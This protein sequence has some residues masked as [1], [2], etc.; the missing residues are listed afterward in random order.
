MMDT[1]GALTTA[2]ETIR[3]YYGEGQPEAGKPPV[4]GADLAAVYAGHGLPVLPAKLTEKK[5]EPKW[6][7]ADATADKK[8]VRQHWPTS[9]NGNPLA[10]VQPMMPVAPRTGLVVIDVDDASDHDT[11]A[12]LAELPPTLTLYRRGPSRE[13][14]RNRFHLVY[15]GTDVYSRK[16]SGLGLEVLGKSRKG[17]PGAVVPLPFDQRSKTVYWPHGDQI[18]DF[19]SELIELLPS[20]RHAE[21]PE[22]VAPLDSECPYAVAA[23]DDILASV[24]NADGQDQAQRDKLFVAALRLG[25]HVASG[26]LDHATTR[27]AL[28]QAVLAA[29]T[30]RAGEPWTREQAEVNADNG[31]ETGRI[32]FDC[33]YLWA[34]VNQGVA[35]ANQ[36]FAVLG[37]QPR[38]IVDRESGEVLQTR[39][40]KWLRREP[41]CRKVA[42]PQRAG[43]WPTERCDGF[44]QVT[45]GKLWINSPF[46]RQWQ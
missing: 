13:Q 16:P 6:R 27:E 8:R 46:A 19:P 18:A 28:V 4:S 15:R 11:A 17:T 22:P 43:T 34:E 45:L 41:L 31:L 42:V 25:R 35:A 7:W 30:L 33:S 36:R 37:G 9:S 39:G 14:W 44:E 21:A 26:Q 40:T 24:R 1:A 12:L 10:N 23:R 20:A 5:R 2:I 3:Q 32:D 38:R 29:P